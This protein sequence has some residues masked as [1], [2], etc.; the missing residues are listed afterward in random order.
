MPVL[1]HVQVVALSSVLHVTLRSSP[2]PLASYILRIDFMEGSCF[3]SEGEPERE[4]FLGI[5]LYIYESISYA[6][7]G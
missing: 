3:F 2:V 1:S 5:I 4:P 7:G 6:K